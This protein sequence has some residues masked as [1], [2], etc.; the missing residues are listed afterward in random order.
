MTAG[1][2]PVSRAQ[3]SAAESVSRAPLSAGEPVLSVRFSA[4][5]H[6]ADWASGPD[7]GMA[8]RHCG[9]DCGNR[10]NGY[11]FHEYLL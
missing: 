9:T 5:G 10:R 4:P 6:T 8:E 1:A 2:E 11:F 7:L 3:V